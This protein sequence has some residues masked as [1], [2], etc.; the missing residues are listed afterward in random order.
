MKHTKDG[1][2]ALVRC[3]ILHSG[4][5]RYVRTTEGY[6]ECCG[7]GFLRSAESIREEQENIINSM[8]FA[9]VMRAE[10]ELS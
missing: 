2:V 6:Y 4:N 7:C 1:Y 10:A 5:T 8:S 3:H 9:D